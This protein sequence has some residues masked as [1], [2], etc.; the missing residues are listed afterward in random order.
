MQIP[1][2]ID[3]E[4][5]ALSY[6]HFDKQFEVNTYRDMA[7]EVSSLGFKTISGWANA[8][9]ADDAARHARIRCAMHSLER[10]GL[11]ESYYERT[12]APTKERVI[13]QWVVGG[14]QFYKVPDSGWR[15]KT[16]PLG[17]EILAQHLAF[18]YKCCD[19][20]VRLFCVCAE[21]TFCAQHGGGCHGTH[22]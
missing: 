12:T 11:V 16:T 19:G 15:Y 3:E 5:V 22:D 21:K 10:F 6:A 18:S 9:P 8:T 4:L 17:E 20:C 2:I 7:G 13:E 1:L 14:K